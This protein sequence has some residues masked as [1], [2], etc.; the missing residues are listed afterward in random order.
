VGVGG[1][2]AS[3]GGSGIAASPGAAGYIIVEEFYQ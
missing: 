2:A 1:T 3:T